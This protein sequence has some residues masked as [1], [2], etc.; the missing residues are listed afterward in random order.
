MGKLP[1]MQFYPADWIQDT[2]TLDQSAKGS[3][4]DILCQM[5]LAPERGVLD[6][7]LDE[8][9]TLL[10]LKNDS[11]TEEM[12]AH[13]ERVADITLFDAQRNQVENVENATHIKLINRRMVRDEEKRKAK[14]LAD[15][16]YNDKRTKKKRSANDTKT[17]DIYQKSEVRS[18]K[19]IRKEKIAPSHR[20]VTVPPP[21]PNDDIWL[22]ELL[23]T[24]VF[25]SH[26][27][28]QLQDYQWWEFA[29]KSLGGIDRAF[30]EKEFA[31]IN[32]WWRENP[33][34]HKTAN[35]MRR[36]IRTWLEKAKNDQGR[37]YAIK[38]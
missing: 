37:V 1:F 31:K 24:Q 14:Q 11:E 3:W 20:N 36:F 17:T 8:F 32:A 38:R 15:L 5:W 25:C 33:T 19:S 35:G 7:C 22:S 27:A 6:W 18:Q 23:K 34:K 2:Q 16:K 10:R 4:I 30:I 26:C 29:A 21:W 13:L 12:V 28:D 9:T